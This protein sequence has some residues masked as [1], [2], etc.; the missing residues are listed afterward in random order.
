MMISIISGL[1][2]VFLPRENK[3]EKL[4]ASESP[5]FLNFSLKKKLPR[6]LGVTEAYDVPSKVLLGRFGRNKQRESF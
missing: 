1:F 5:W 6:R 3:C 2:M 4:R